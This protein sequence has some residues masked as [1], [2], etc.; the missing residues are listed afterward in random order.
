MV[1]ICGTNMEVQDLNDIDHVEPED[2]DTPQ[3]IKIDPDNFNVLEFAQ[4]QRIL[5]GA[6]NS[7]SIYVLFRRRRDPKMVHSLW[8]KRSR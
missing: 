8:T 5:A 1:E 7:I 6:S 4:R 2:K 3:L